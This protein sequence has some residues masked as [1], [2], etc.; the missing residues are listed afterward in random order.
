MTDLDETEYQRW[1]TTG[2][3]TLEAAR[4]LAAGDHH[5]GAVFSAEQAVQCAVKALLHGVGLGARARGHDLLALAGRAER[6]A[7]LVLDDGQRSA[8][9]ELATSYAPSRYPDA[10]PGGT[11]SDY[12]GS[13]QSAQ[14][15]TT[16][17]ALLGLVDRAWA[18]L[19]AA[20]GQEEE[21]DEGS[22]DER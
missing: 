3:A 5:P 17:E 21:S 20:T 13:E 22:G 19:I 18:S 9:R 2:D 1:R 15:L 10:L 16:A 6:E 12:F 4:S 8:L 7:A 11:P 14:A